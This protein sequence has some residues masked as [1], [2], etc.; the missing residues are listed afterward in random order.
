MKVLYTA[1]LALL[2]F[3]S[4]RRQSGDIDSFLHNAESL[5]NEHPED[6]LSIIRHIDRRKIYSS[7]SEARYA[8]L[9]SQALD[10]NYVDVTSDSLTAV[11]VNY[12][13]RH[14][15]KHERAMAHYYQGRVFSNAGNF[16]AAIRSYSL[17]ED[18]ASGTDDYYLLG[19]INNAVGNLH[20]EQYDLDEALQRDQ[21]AASFFHRAQ[22]P[23]NEALAYIGVGTVYSLKGDNEQMEIVYNKAIE[24]YKE[25]NATDKILPLYEDIIIETKLNTGIDLSSIKRDLRHYYTI[26]NN[27]RIPIQSMG[28]WQGIYLKANELDSARLC[29]EIILRNRQAFNA[30]KIAG[31]YSLLERIEMA[32][33]NYPEAYRYVKQYIAV[34]DSINQEKEEALVLELE[35][36]YR[37]RI[38]NQS[39][40]N[41]KQ[42]NDQQRIITG[43]VLL[44]SL[45]LLVAGL[46]YLRKWRENA[47]LKMREAEAEKES[48][49]RA[50]R[51]LQEQLGTVG[52]RVD[53]DDEQERQLFD[54][55]EERMV[56][57]RNW[58][59][60]AETMKPALFMKS[61]CDYMTVNVKSKHALSD[62]QYVVNR[63]YFGV[64]DYL[65]AHYP[66]LRKQDLDLCC[67]L[68]FGFSQHGICYL[69]NYEDI[70]SFY[71]K[72]SRLRK[73][74]G[75]PPERT[76]ESFIAELLAELAP[77]EE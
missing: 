30:H 36:K 65:K 53:T 68:C 1:L 27:G 16:D 8:L 44:F 3:P 64:V 39:Y 62:L 47:A 56:V 13:D 73:K 52:D 37:N 29:G 32:R 15:T 63:K 58:V 4:C 10:K 17:A 5:M 61:F 76:L 49:G 54:A 21:Q 38:L 75:L 41:L 57:L 12:Y 23:Y 42:H 26:Y 46:L 43:L 25:L 55:L 31:C 66:E 40:E 28:L 9:Y 24:I 74:L 77:K 51:E 45:S 18:A 11:A 72:R 7:A 60:K 48:L 14:G 6:A 34:M 20:F 35:Q 50:C 33:G 19:L 22:S 70:G 71:N 59:D 67:L 69:Y 2:L